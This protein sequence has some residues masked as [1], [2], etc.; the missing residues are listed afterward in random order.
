MIVEIMN[1]ISEGQV[2]FIITATVAILAISVIVYTYADR[3]QS[4]FV[5]T[6]NYKILA[7]LGLIPNAQSRQITKSDIDTGVR[8][9]SSDGKEFALIRSGSFPD[10]GLVFPYR[11]K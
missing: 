4:Y 8:M 7:E 6:P 10:I 11:I 5:N 9:V 3:P 2:A 1:K